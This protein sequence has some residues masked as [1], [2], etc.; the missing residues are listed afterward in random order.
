[1]VWNQI[2]GK[3]SLNK[4]SFLFVLGLTTSALLLS[5]AHADEYDEKEQ[6]TQPT[7]YY[8]NRFVIGGTTNF[9]ATSTEYKDYSDNTTFTN[10]VDLTDGA[11]TFTAKIAFRGYLNPNEINSGFIELE[12]F[13]DF[14]STRAKDEKSYGKYDLEI[15]PSFGGKI[16][17]GYEMVNKHAVSVNFG[18]QKFDYKYKYDNGGYDNAEKNG[19]SLGILMGVAYEYNICQYVGLNF[20]LDYSFFDFETPNKNIISGTKIID[21]MENTT[22]AFKVGLN[23]K[24]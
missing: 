8:K 20:I 5:S 13:K 24:F 14:G 6:I 9:I 19:N 17:I 15:E 4:K 18:L 12:A 10:N 22:L 3:M 7:N 11:T 16:S 2:G 21:N 23:F 1:M